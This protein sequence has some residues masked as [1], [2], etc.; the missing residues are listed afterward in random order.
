MAL[1]GWRIG[2]KRGDRR[3]PRPGRKAAMLEGISPLVTSAFAVHAT[4]RTESGGAFRVSLSQPLR[5]E[6][7]SARL[8]I[9]AG[10]T[11]DGRVVRQRVT[12]GLAPEGRQVDLAL[13]WRQ[14]TTWG[15]YRLGATLSRHPGHRRGADLEAVLLSGWR[16]AF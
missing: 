15:E 7:G 12:A 1:G 9:P 2:G 14:P 8:A 11:R 13:R 10:R 16:V 3:D 4:R 6:D 5:V